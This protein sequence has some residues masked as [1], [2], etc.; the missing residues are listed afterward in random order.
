MNEHHFQIL[1]YLYIKKKKKPKYTIGPK[2][3]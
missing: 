1:S 2:T 3:F